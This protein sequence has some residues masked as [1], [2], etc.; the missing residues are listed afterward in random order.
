[1][2]INV[3]KAFTSGDGF[4]NQYL[5]GQI[6]DVS[7]DVANYAI[8]QDWAKT[9]A[10]QPIQPIVETVAAEPTESA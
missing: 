10:E 1:M 8:S 5:E 9:A 2:L 6:I 4:V 7:D 3:L